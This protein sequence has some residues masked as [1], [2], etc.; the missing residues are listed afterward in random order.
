M[1]INHSN[2]KTQVSQNNSSCQ[3]VFK[4]TSDS[5]AWKKDVEKIRLQKNSKK[6]NLFVGVFSCS[7]V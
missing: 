1:I 4:A 6:L 2:N 7:E 3:E 5:Y